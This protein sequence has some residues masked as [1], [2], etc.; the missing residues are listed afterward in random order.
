MI[1]L[2]IL[3]NQFFVGLFRGSEY[4]LIASGLALIFGVLRTINF[5]HATLLVLGGYLAFSF[6][7]F[8][9][10]NLILTIVMATFIVGLIGAIIMRSLLKPLMKVDPIYQLLVT[11]AVVLI[12]NNMAKIIWGGEPIYVSIP[13]VLSQPIAQ[14]VPVSGYMFFYI[15]AGVAVYIL[16]LYMINRTLF[17]LKV[18]AVWRKP[19]I[20]EALGINMDNI[21]TLVFSI[22]CAIAGFGGSLLVLYSPVIPG[23]GDSL[24]ISAFVVVVLAG[25]GNIT[26]TYISALLIGV[27]EALFAIIIP[28]LDLLL[29]YLIMAIVLLIRPQ[30]LFG[31][32]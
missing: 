5:A 28:E 4:W 15:I 9:T 24:I 12:L 20:S 18:R 21:Y 19:E 11:F 16:L 8:F 2:Q 26:G 29:I 25:L 10:G 6:Y 3:L 17:G 22:G 30:G 14:G 31:E 27:L 23:L 32:R 7:T 13:E 1:D